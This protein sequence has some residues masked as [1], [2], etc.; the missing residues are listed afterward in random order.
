AGAIS[1]VVPQKEGYVYKQGGIESADGCCRPFESRADGTV[2]SN[3]VG[4]VVLKRLEDALADNDT[5]FAVIKGVGI[6]NDGSD[7]LG[8]TAPSVNG[9]IE[10]IREALLHSKVKAK[11]IGYIEAHGTAT[12]LGDAVEV[13][14]LSTVF[15]EQTSKKQ[16]CA[17]GSVKGNIGHTD[18]ASGIAG[19][20]KAALCLF[21]KKIPPMPNFEQYNPHIQFEESPFFV[22]S[23]LI[24]WRKESTHPLYAGVSSF[25]V[26]GTNVHMILS[27]HVSTPVHLDEVS[28][29]LVVLSAKTE[30]ALQQNIEKMTNFLSNSEDNVSLADIAYTLQTGRET[31]E[32]RC[33]CVGKTREEVIKNLPLS[34]ISCCDMA[35][36]PSIVFMFPGQGMQYPQMAAELMLKIPFFSSLVQRGIAIAKSYLDIDLLEIINNPS[37]ARLNQT[38][39]AQPALF[40]IEYALAH[41]LIHYGI[42]PSAVIGHSLGEYVAACI[43]GVFSFEEAIALVCQRGFLM[44]SAPAG[45]MLAI[46][47]TREELSSYLEYTELA[48]HNS[49]THFVVAGKAA[50][51]NQLEKILLEAEKPFRKLK[52]NHSFHSQSMEGI[53]QPLKDL[54]VN[55]T[56]SA[57]Q[58]PMI[59]NVTGTWLS[60]KEAMDPHYWYTHLR[61]TVQFCKGI[62]TLLEDSHPLFLEVGPGQS[63]NVFL[64]DIASSHK[65][66]VVSTSTLMANYALKSEFNQLIAAIGMVWQQGIRINWLTFHEEASRRHTPL[67]TYA[68][69]KQKYWIDPDVKTKRLDN[70]PT[71]Y[72]PIWSQQLVCPF[73]LSDTTTKSLQDNT[74]I[75]FKDKL[76][77]ADQVITFLKKKNTSPI[78]IEMGELYF[79]EKSRYFKINPANKDH[80]KKL[81]SALRDKLRNPIVLHCFTCANTGDGMLSYKE[82]DAQLEL[83]FF[84]ILYLAQSYLECIGDQTVLKTLI[85]STGTQQVVGSE[86][87]S[88]INA[89]LIGPCRVLSKEHSFMQ[90]KLLDITLN[91]PLFSSQN[92]LSLLFGVCLNEAWNAS[93]SV[94][95]YRNNYRWDLTYEL[96]KSYSSAFRFKDNGTY[97][98][99]G[100]LGGIVLMLCEAITKSIKKPRFILLSRSAMI[101][102]EEWDSALQDPSH[103]FHQ[104]ISHL[105]KMQILG[106]QFIFHQVDVTDFESLS[107]IINHYT[108]AEKIHGVIHGAG[109]A[110]GGLMVLKSKKEAQEI[111]LPKIHGTYNLA[112][113]FQDYPLDFVVLLSSIAA[114][115]GEPGQID[116]CAANACLDAFAVSKLFS[117]SFVLSINWNTWRDIGM[118]VDAARI[119]KENFLNRGNDISS[120]QGQQL[121]LQAMQRQ[122]ANLIISNFDIDYYSTKDNGK[123]VEEKHALPKTSRQNVKTSVAYVPPNNAIENQLAGLW[124]ESLGIEQIG[125]NDDFF[126]LGGHSL[127]AINLIEKI[128]KNFNCNLP[129]TQIYHDPT[130]KQLCKTILKTTENR[131]SYTPILLKKGEEH[132]PYLFLGHPI[133]GLMNCYQS[134]VSQSELPMSIYGIQD[135]SIEANELLYNSLAAMVDDYFSMIRKIQP[136]GPYFLL[137]YSFGGNI[138][139]EIASKLLKQGEKVNLL[140]LIDSWAIKSPALKNETY[141]KL[142]FK[143]ASGLSDE[144]TNLA[145]KRE[146][147]SLAHSISKL[148]HEML[149]FKASYLSDIYRTIDDPTN[150]WAKYNKGK[151][152]CHALEGNHDTVMN[153]N[154]SKIILQLIEQYL[155]ERYGIANEVL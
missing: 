81:F 8:Y 11:E 150:G 134:L 135:P 68:F 121:F 80:Y 36:H 1:I 154:N 94:V 143:E 16:Y 108:S 91:D 59:S 64:K 97:L 62:E 15:R 7:K 142:Y 95:A 69:Q 58:I 106:A 118:A 100:G 4:V 115:T 23:Q 21:H 19:L 126:V 24:E 52:V 114:I 137:G 76:G 84:S 37:D 50:E 85:L 42:T 72:K 92:F 63:L 152:I 101:P 123:I 125:I 70:K 25:G 10:C 110:G 136:T 74:W 32:W 147:L 67:P 132:F 139:F 129:A 140:A 57:P 105:K 145:W 38:Q 65:K 153:A 55:F 47:C 9:Q 2:F 104:K 127:K 14:A 88:P 122:D 44:A 29:S 144:I 109:V 120:A 26:G 45:E 35:I 116:Y 75:I 18:V 3:G 77:I 82:I 90:C 51:I 148:D 28:E 78:V 79:E 112:K 13:E 128:N 138:L 60:A 133:S 46:E 111:L 155:K 124:Q 20:M 89:G 93:H 119:Y 31:F 66:E 102:E 83:G 61:H 22:N 151:I 27:E 34:P 130:I 103:V 99:T 96:A 12:S 30:K 54:F 131:L 73:E 117:S 56:L 43:A 149:L 6:N 113:I 39:Y 5:I 41:L 71:F 146:Q 87:V 107:L 40:I 86:N 33:F 53:E 98:I 49:T 141:F 17:L 48:L